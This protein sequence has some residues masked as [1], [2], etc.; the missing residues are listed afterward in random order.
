MTTTTP[1]TIRRLAAGLLVFA[2]LGLA[3]CGST[4]SS[5]STPAASPTTTQSS[6]P[7]ATTSGTTATT[8]NGIPQGPGAGDQ[9]ADNSGGPSDGDGN[10]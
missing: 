7:P 10:L 4:A 5:S 1:R 2:A 6:T 8:K 9:D 3:A